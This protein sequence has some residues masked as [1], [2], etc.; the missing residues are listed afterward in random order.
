MDSP[1]SSGAAKRTELES[2][3]RA[4]SYEAFGLGEEIR[5]RVDEEHPTLDQL[6]KRCGRTEW[7][8]LTAWNP[9]SSLR[10]KAQNEAANHQLFERLKGL[11]DEQG[12]PF[13]VLPGRGVGDDP[14][15]DAE[16]SFLVLGIS[17]ERAEALSQEFNQ[18]ARLAGSHGRPARLIWSAPRP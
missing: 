2:A 16:E 1:D 4:T 11:T 10:T 14:G 9:G 13:L 15:W 5:L 12:R 3:F 6:L 18:C 7:A 17:S 8:F